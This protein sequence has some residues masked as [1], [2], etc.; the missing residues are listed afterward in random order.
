MPTLAALSPFF[1]GALLTFK[2]SSDDEWLVKTME[3]DLELAQIKNIY[4]KEIQGLYAQY[5]RDKADQRTDF[6]SLNQDLQKLR[7]IAESEGLHPRY[8]DELVQAHQYSLS[9]HGGGDL[10]QNSKRKLKKAA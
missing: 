7:K 8:F 9:G 3:E 10:R 4:R 5:E 1:V 6:A 2:S